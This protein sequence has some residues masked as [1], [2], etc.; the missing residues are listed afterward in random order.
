MRKLEQAERVLASR[1]F[2]TKG[3]KKGPHALRKDVQD[4]QSFY[5]VVL[6]VQKRHQTALDEALS[7]KAMQK[8]IRKQRKARAIQAAQAERKRT[9]AISDD[10]AY[11]KR[12]SR[13]ADARL[14][15]EFQRDLVVR[16]LVRTREA[17]SSRG[18]DVPPVPPGVDLD[19]VDPLG[20]YR[21]QEY[22]KEIDEFD[23]HM[24]ASLPFLTV[25]HARCRLRNENPP[26]QCQRMTSLPA[27][28]S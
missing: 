13:R 20:D 7:W 28:S 15:D 9:A 1:R 11:I 14:K 3:E 22:K 4:A 5:E 23:A 21:L 27:G 24:Q 6:M 19:A 17:L 10:L 25:Q 16:D 8:E 12:L 2:L 18:F 26:A